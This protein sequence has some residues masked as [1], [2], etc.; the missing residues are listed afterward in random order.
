MR[1]GPTQFFDKAKV[2]PREVEELVL[3]MVNRIRS[4]AGASVA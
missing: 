1:S 2:K 3:A 4:A